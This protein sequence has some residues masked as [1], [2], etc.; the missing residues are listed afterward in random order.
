[1]PG[2]PDGGVEL[3]EMPNR[4]PDHDAIGDLLG[5]YALGAVD[6]KE[7]RRIEVHLP[8]CAGCREELARHRTAVA[9]LGRL[10]SELGPDQ[11]AHL[12]DVG[13]KVRAGPH[14]PPAPP[15]ARALPRRRGVVWGLGVAT[16]ILLVVSLATVT[17]LAGR[18]L[19]RVEGRLARAELIEQVVARATDSGTRTARL[20]TIGGG[21]SVEVVALA[22]GTAMVWKNR[23]PALS[24][25]RSYFLW[26][27]VT[28]Q[29]VPVGR[30]DSVGR[31]QVVRVP[32][33]ANAMVVTEERSSGPPEGTRIVVVG[34]FEG[35]A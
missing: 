29:R 6:P 20:S 16:V 31:P 30:L 33:G 2:I 22:D 1:M 11:A 21:L 9:G 27:V 17:V 34:G 14:G 19:D 7:R 13:E 15:P 10:A 28:A 32:P 4:D 23:L 8:S 3:S 35:G 5:A 24:P 25:E 18:R 26:A 12:M